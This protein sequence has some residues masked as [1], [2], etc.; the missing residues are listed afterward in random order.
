MTYV[1]E[2]CNGLVIAITVVVVAVPEG[3]PLAVTI[4][5]AF[6]V[7]KMQEE[8]NLVRKLHSSE[9]MGNANE[10]C[11]DKTGTLTMNKMSV[12]SCYLEDKI[13][14]GE[15]SDIQSLGSSEFI[16]SAVIF[17]CT[18][19]ID[20]EKEGQPL[21][22]NVTEVGLLDYLRKSNVNVLERCQERDSQKPIFTIPFSSVRKRQTTV[23]WVNGGQTARV[24]VKGAP[25]IV[26]KYCTEFYDSN[27][28]VSPLEQDKKDYAINTVVKNYAA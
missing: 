22:G 21:T 11:T 28:Q 27:A 24:F 25:E 17:N 26:I 9:T 6:S 16:Q 23:M 14:A 12:Q 8:N 18:A 10:I 1:A 2:L 13:I 3:L 19:Y 15:S 20:A 4:S 7:K 5:L